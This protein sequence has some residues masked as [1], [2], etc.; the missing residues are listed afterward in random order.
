VL[1]SFI[2]RAVKFKFKQVPYKGL[3]YIA[4]RCYTIG[5]RTPVST[6]VNRDEL[7]KE[8]TTLGHGKYSS[9]N[10]R[11]SV[12]RRKSISLV[13]LSSSK[14]QRLLTLLRISKLQISFLLERG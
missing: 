13:S 3:A 9:T 11:R 1:L 8:G 12:R 4:K 10:L 6:L 2:Y 7:V 5:R 14:V